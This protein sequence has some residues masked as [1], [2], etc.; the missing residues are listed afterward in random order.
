MQLVELYWHCQKSLA[1]LGK[2]L[3]RSYS[4]RISL[5]IN[6]KDCSS[7]GVCLGILNVNGNNVPSG[8]RE[9]HTFTSDLSKDSTL[10]LKML[11]CRELQAINYVSSHNKFIKS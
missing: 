1:F 4:S 5:T 2:L 8:R 3:A 9:V 7:L 6:P 10:L 11:R